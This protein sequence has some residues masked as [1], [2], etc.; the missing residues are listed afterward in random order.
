MARFFILSFALA[1]FS[2]LLFGRW[3][4]TALDRKNQT[5]VLTDRV[6]NF[7]SFYEIFGLTEAKDF[8]YNGPCVIIKKEIALLFDDRGWGNSA[9]VVGRR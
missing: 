9:V 3:V 7:L 5:G 2:C 1:L 4:L 8:R 6:K